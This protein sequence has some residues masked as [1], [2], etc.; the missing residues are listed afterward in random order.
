MSIQIIP[1]GRLS[2]C[3]LRGVIEEFISRNGTDYGE[4]EILLETKIRQV[5]SQLK[6]K[7]VVLVFDDEDETTNIV[8]VDDPVLKKLIDGGH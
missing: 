2:A 7:T 5:E 1:F 8:R 4:T 3:A 6:N